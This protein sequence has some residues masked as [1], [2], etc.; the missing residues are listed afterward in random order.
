MTFLSDAELA[1]I[2]ADVLNLLPDTCNLLT[3]TNTSDGQGGFT[4]T[5][6][7]VDTCV[8]CRLDPIRGSEQIAGE[9]IRPFH[10]FVLTLPYDVTITEQYRV[11]IGTYT[12][13]VTSIDP[14]KSWRA[15]VRAYVEV[16]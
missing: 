9:A 16:V 12:Y 2:R 10:T 5:W 1:A 6:G 4:Q 7:T 8:K 15:S 3:V 13:N 14:N 11:E